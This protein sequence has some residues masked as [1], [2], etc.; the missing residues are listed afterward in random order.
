MINKYN[1][2]TKTFEMQAFN[3]LSK[4]NLIDFRF[5]NPLYVT[6]LLNENMNYITQRNEYYYK[7]AVDIGPNYN[8]LIY[9][10]INNHLCCDLITESIICNTLIV[11][12]IYNNTILLGGPLNKSLQVQYDNFINDQ[13]QQFN[14]DDN[15]L[16]FLNCNC[17]TFFN[18]DPFTIFGGFYYKNNILY[19][20]IRSIQKY[21]Y[22]NC[23]IVDLDKTFHLTSNVKQINTLTL[24][25][26]GTLI[27]V[28][29]MNEMCVKHLYKQ[30]LN[31]LL[32]KFNI[33]SV[34]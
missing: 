28:Y 3:N 26:H 29:V 4:I 32:N 16:E 23:L 5:H 19:L 8:E 11:N 27:N 12:Y 18:D 6:E 13:Q 25:G 14:F 17:I 10:D 31:S 24:Q 21:D 9:K 2:I 20:I 30:Y 1:F 22:E 33:C 7:Y 15:F 34:D